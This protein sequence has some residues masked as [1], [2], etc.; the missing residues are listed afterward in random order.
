MGAWELG[1]VGERA[2]GSVGVSERG[3][4]GA[5]ALGRIGAGGAWERGSLGVFGNIFALPIS[6]FLS[7]SEKEH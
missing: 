7:I 1:G 3:S 5:R 4:M 6:E 2:L